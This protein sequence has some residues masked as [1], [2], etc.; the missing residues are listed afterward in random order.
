MYN[1]GPKLDGQTVEA[2]TNLLITGPPLS[3]KRQL[4]LDI[5]KQGFEDDEGGI[6]I[7]TKDSGDRIVEEYTRTGTS[8]D[9]VPLDIRE[10]G[11]Q[12]RL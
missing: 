2:G 8:L 5:L 11:R 3:G 10:S 4:A 9:N 12:T 7:S 1:L 6:V